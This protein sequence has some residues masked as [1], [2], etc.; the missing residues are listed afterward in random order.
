MGS[1]PT[2]EE[3]NCFDLLRLVMAL[4]VVY[5]H[6]CVIGGFGQEKFLALVK[7]QSTAGGLAV[8]GFFGMSGF[9]VARSYAV[10]PGAGRFIRARLLRV[11]PGLYLAL[12]LVAFVF[13]P[14]INHFNPAGGGWKIGDAASFVVR[15]AG[16]KVGQ[17]SVGGVL[18]GLP[19]SFSIDGALWTLFPELWCYGLALLLGMMGGLRQHRF[20]LLLALGLVAILHGAIVLA[21][22]REYVAPTVLTL[23]G[24]DPLFTAFLTGMALYAFRS[25]ADAGYPP[26]LFWCAVAGLLLR[27]GGWSLLGPVALP[28]GLRYLAYAGCIRL[29]VDLSYGIYILHFPALQLLAAL[30]VNRLGLPVYL[31]LGLAVTLP[32]AAASWHFVE[33]PALALKAWPL[34]RTG[35]RGL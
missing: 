22:H 16:V 2:G 30:G 15:N 9:L 34:R 28:I 19:F 26:A 21:P 29:P 25:D 33:R 14:A 7:G 3:K 8:L 35:G 23:T 10:H 27:F 4:L 31:G 5:T 6:A 18:A 13:A 11:M 24:W 1:R 20:H 12:V 32:L 17:W